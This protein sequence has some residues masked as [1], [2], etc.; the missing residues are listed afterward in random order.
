MLYGHD[1]CRTALLR[2]LLLMHDIIQP[3][4]PFKFQ[5]D[6]FQSPMTL[7]LLDVNKCT[8]K[9]FLY[10]FILIWFDNHWRS[11][12]I[13]RGKGGEEGTTARNLDIG[14][15]GQITGGLGLRKAWH[16]WQ[17]QCGYQCRISQTRRQ[18]R[19]LHCDS[20]CAAPLRSSNS[21]PNDYGNNGNKCDHNDDDSS[22]GPIKRSRLVDKCSIYWC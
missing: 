7:L 19:W 21:T 20:D 4:Q 1:Q 12:G 16:G 15:C 18:R 11:I 8:I 22:C 3:E 10:K 9:I 6:P 5:R 14:G 17:E 13:I 2:L